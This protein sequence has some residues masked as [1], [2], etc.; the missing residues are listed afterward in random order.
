[1]P[2]PGGGVGGADRADRAAGFGR[3]AG[4][5]ST[6]A[7]VRQVITVGRDESSRRVR[8]A[9][10][11]CPSVGLTG[12][13]VPARFPLVAAAV[14]DGGVGVRQAGLICATISGF[15]GRVG[16]ELRDA[17]EQFLVGQARVVD[18]K[19]L[20]QVAREIALMADPDG[21]PDDRDAQERMQFHLGRRRED[22]LTKCWGLLDDVTAEA[23]R[24]AFG[25]MCSPSA[26]RNR[27]GRPDP[28]AAQDGDGG[29]RAAGG[30][31]VNPGATLP[32][33]RTSTTSRRN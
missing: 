16:Q 20:E 9:A 28:S 33:R 11:I 18:P 32:N 21:T 25:A 13:V 24:T 6:S 22:G 5:S 27:T 4:A 30:R 19:T 3:P 17:A 1:M 23:L 8:L 2:P 29:D 10:G 14:A 15:P 31:T 12:V 7:L 26:E